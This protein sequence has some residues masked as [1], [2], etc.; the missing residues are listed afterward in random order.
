MTIPRSTNTT[1]AW[2]KQAICGRDRHIKICIRR[3]LMATRHKWWLAHIKVIQW[4]QMKL[5]DL[6]PRTTGNLTYFKTPQKLN[7]WQARWHL[8]LSEYDI[9]LIHV[10]GKQMVQSDALSQWPDLCPDEDTNNED[11]ILLPDTMFVR[12][13]HT[14]LK[15]LIANNKW[16]ATV[17]LKAIQALRG[18]EQ[19]P[20]NSKIDDWTFDDSLIFYKDKC[21][22]PNDLDLQQKILGKY[23]DAMPIGHPGQLC[24][25][26]II[27]RDYW[28]PSLH[29]FCWTS[30]L[31]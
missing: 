23:H 16:H 25:Q 19:L 12:L 10:P 17:I 24:T 18:G 15:D 14:E 27:Q 13:I 1:N 29:T 30:I 3:H 8:M 20:M 21:Y 7:R 22:I 4:N 11:K 5:W 6:W 9:K 28:W 2:P 26:E 31:D